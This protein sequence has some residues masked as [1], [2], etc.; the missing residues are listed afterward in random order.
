MSLC[1]WN[2]LPGVIHLPLFALLEACGSINEKT[3]LMVVRFHDFMEGYNLSLTSCFSPHWYT[4]KRRYN[5]AELPI[6]LL[7]SRVIWHLSQSNYGD[8]VEVICLPNCKIN[9]ELG[10]PSEGWKCLRNGHRDV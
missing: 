4:V 6:V 3:V 10:P 2:E 7:G 8:S 9:R 5:K 1:S